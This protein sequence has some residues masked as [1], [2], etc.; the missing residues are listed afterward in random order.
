MSWRPEHAIEIVAGT[1]PGGGLDRTARALAAALEHVRAL[2]VPVRVTNVPG[3]GSR[4]AWQYIDARDGDPHVLGISHPNMTT[5]EIIGVASF[6]PFSYT[7]IAVLCTEYIAFMVRGESRLGSATELIDLIRARQGRV[8]VA[9]S[10]ALGNP[11]HVALCRLLRHAGVDVLEP[12][13]RVFDSAL[14]AVADVLAARADVAAVTAASTLQALEAGRARVLAIS[15][16]R[17]IPGALGAVPTWMETGVDC[18]IGAWRGVSG[19]RSIAPEHVR[20]WE[21]ALTRA[22]G[23]A[24]WK[25]ALARHGWSPTYADGTPLHRLLRDEQVEFAAVL[26]GLGLARPASTP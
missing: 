1:A 6:G 26:A 14:D 24:L 9:L 2:E 22:T 25:E 8:T 23:D 4:K 16:P 3:D 5:D 18:T 15:S 20:F 7:P 10:T 17:R 21:D 11:N 12:A 13:I 19:A